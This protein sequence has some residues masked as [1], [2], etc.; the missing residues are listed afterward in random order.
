MEL[1]F[2]DCRVPAENLLGDEGKGF[3][4]AMWALDGGRIGI[5]S[6]ALGIAQAALD[7]SIKYSRE[8]VQFKRPISSFQAIQWKIAE[9]AMEIE[10]ARLLVRKA[11]WLRDKGMDCTKEAC[12]GK[13]KASETSVRAAEDAVQI[14]G[15]AG[16]TKAFPV[17]RF[18]RDSRI[19]MIYEGT[20]EALRIILARRLIE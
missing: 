20:S 5:G 2:D 3:H 10:A 11:A 4:I 17:E 16:Y 14:H 13:I 9:M 18:F 19:T 12:M 8:R 15:G 6:Q 1:V 7:A